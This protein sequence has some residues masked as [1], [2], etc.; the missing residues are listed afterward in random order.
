MQRLSFRASLSIVALLVTAILVVLFIV[1]NSIADPTP[2]ETIP[3]LAFAENRSIWKKQGIGSYQ[4]VVDTIYPPQPP[5]GLELI[6]QDGVVTTST[7]LA[8][9]KPSEEYP[10]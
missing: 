2:S 10:Q 9:E 8:C 1:L 7:I 5:I 6:I 4:M 3:M